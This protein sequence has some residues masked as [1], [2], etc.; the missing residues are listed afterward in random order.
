ME[1]IDIKHAIER[2]GLT[3]S[4]IA[5]RRGVSRSLVNL[6]IRHGAVSTHVRE[7]IAR[8]IGRPVE[9]IWPAYYE[10]KSLNH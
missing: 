7:E 1:P 2:A 8:V 4:D 6:V 5:R 9:Q 3:Q 10:R